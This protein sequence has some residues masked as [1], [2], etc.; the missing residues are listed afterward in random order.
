MN[1]ENPPPAPK[2]MPPE[3]T[4]QLVLYRTEDWRTRISCR[5]GDDSV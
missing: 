4:G 2:P 3:G 5:V 1:D